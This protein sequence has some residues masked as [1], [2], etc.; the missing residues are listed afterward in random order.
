MGASPLVHIAFLAGSPERTLALRAALQAVVTP[1]SSVLDAGCGPLG[2]L[3]I[4][5]AKLGAKRVTGVDVVPL[6]M[7]RALARENGV[8]DKVT[9]VQADLSDLESEQGPFDVIV[10]MIYEN[11]PRRDSAQ[12]ALMAELVARFGNE[13]TKIIP[14]RVRYWVAGFSMSI[15]DESDCTRAQEWTEWFDRVEHETGLGFAA[16]WQ[17]I[18]RRWR[19]EQGLGQLPPV[20]RSVSSRF[21]YPDRRGMR[22]LT[23]REHVVEVNYS[24]PTIRTSLPSTVRLPVSRDGALELTIWRQDLVFEDLVL[25]STETVYPVHPACEVRAGDEA[26]LQTLGDWRYGIPLLVDRGAEK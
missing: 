16:A 17:L 19:D 5:A 14:D 18:N 10:G 25:R 24:L 11:D 20:P 15:A 26:V 2:A 7:A 4:V 21:N 3:A 22:V 13:N 6:D 23:P 12:Q 8:A 1:C 9:F